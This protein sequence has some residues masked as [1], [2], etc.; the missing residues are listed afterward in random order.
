MCTPVIKA[1]GRQRQMVIEFETSLA[2]LIRLFQ[3]TRKTNK[4]S[5]KSVITRSF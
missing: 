2:Y 1:L 5:I 3:N 4:R